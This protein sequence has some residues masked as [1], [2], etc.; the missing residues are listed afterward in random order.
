MVDRAII[1]ALSIWNQDILGQR[2]GT[3]RIFKVKMKN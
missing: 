1:C 2:N 3:R